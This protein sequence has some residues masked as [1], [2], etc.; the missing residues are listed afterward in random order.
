[1]IS[2]LTA[3][4]RVLAFCLIAPLVCLTCG[5]ALAID[6]A[7]ELWDALVVERKP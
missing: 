1:M 7:G 3:S 2:I 5:L 4:L 6:V